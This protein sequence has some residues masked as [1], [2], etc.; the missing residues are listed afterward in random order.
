M[1]RMF[2]SILVPHDFSDSATF[3]LRAAADLAASHRG[4][5]TVLHVLGPF[6]TGP[7]Y[8]SSIAIAWTP[9]KELVAE[10]QTQLQ[11]LVARTLGKRA[12]AV[13]CRVVTGDPLRCI[14][15]AARRADCIVMAT[16]GRTGL[17]H[18]LIGSVAEKVVRHAPVPVITIRPPVRTR[19][20]DGH[21]GQRPRSPVRRSSAPGRAG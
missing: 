21:G 6:Y 5:L 7:G 18:V 17:A 12:K 1:T 3:A 19:R 14:L 20:R 10:L 9:S 2:R 11:A 15:A 8:P 13:D 4:R 16:V